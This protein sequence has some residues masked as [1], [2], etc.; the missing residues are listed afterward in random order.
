MN[1]EEVKATFGEN[2]EDEEDKDFDIFNDKRYIPS[3]W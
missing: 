3:F 1:V 2:F